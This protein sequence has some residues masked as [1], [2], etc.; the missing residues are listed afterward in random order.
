[1]D[2]FKYQDEGK[3]TKGINSAYLRKIL[4][5]KDDQIKEYERFLINNSAKIIK[6]GYVVKE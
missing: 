4:H 2:A 1:M 5:F 6:P 3:I